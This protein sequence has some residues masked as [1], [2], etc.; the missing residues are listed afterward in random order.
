MEQYRYIVSLENWDIEYR[1]YIDIW[2]EVFGKKCRRD[3]RNRNNDV[4]VNKLYLA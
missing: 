1:E 3:R 2:L 4:K